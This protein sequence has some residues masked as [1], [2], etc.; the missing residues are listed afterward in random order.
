MQILKNKFSLL[1]KTCKYH[2]LIGKM[3]SWGAINKIFLITLKL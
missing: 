1:A 2:G 3:S